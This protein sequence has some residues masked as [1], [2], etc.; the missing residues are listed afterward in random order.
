MEHRGLGDGRLRRR[1]HVPRQRVGAPVP[2]CPMWALPSRKH[3]PHPRDR[4]QNGA[5]NRH[6]RTATLGI[7]RK[8]RSICGGMGK[9]KR[10]GG[11][12]L[13]LTLVWFLFVSTKTYNALRTSRRKA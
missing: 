7:V 6:G 3:V 11:Q 10:G 4:R 5:G 13:F 8:L 2:R 1:R 12:P 9:N